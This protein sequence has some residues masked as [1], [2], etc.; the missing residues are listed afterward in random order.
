MLT[1][2]PL[3]VLT[4]IPEEIA[5]FGAHL[6]Q[7][8]RE[9][10]AGVPVYRGSLDGRPVVVAESGIGKVNGALATALL[11][12]RFV[13]RGVIFS[14]VAGGLDP[15]LAIGD[16]VIATEVVQHDYGAI[17]DG[18][19]ETYRAGALPFPEFRG[20][21]AFRA[22]LRLIAAARA[23]VARASV[24]RD[25]DPRSGT[26]HFGRILTGDS[27]LGCAATRERLFDGFGGKAIDMESGAVAQ[28]AEAFGVP[29]LIIRALSDLAGE[30]SRLNFAAF[31]EQAAGRAA[32]L[33][34]SL[35][36]AFDS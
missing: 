10:V 8:G 5:A 19:L 31:V 23:S 12:D 17:A 20:D 36:P 33:V 29:W 27:Y 21:L 4:A 18:A 2:R 35:L 24:A 34:L 11:L 1:P 13:C 9:M 25:G 30:D 6:T 7:S 3:G 26:I 16:L 28:V 15:A 22:D 32:A 14:G